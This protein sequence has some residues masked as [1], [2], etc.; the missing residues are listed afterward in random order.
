MNTPQPKHEGRSWVLIF[1]CGLWFLGSVW[2]LKLLLDYK[3]TPGILGSAPSQWPKEST[4]ARASDRAVLVIVAHPQCPC[5]RAT[6]EE[7]AWIMTR[8]SGKIQAFVLF[9]KP[10]EFSSEWVKTD[11]WTSAQAIP[12]VRVV[13]DE[14]GSEMA[15]FGASTS[16]QTL[17]YDAHGRL[18]FSGGITPS[19]GHLGES[20]GREA[21][22][23]CAKGA[24]TGGLVNAPVFGCSLRSSSS[25]LLKEGETLWRIQ[26]SLKNLLAS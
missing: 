11:I 24:T 7:L 5:T 6:V 21:I 17:L 8:T 13:M 26:Q 15:H 1:F 12:G 2:G 10:R 9:W 22:L 16:G 20:R 14:D 18:V 25:D 3:N 19:R 4:L 23:A